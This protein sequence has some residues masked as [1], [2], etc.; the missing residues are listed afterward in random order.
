[1][2]AIFKINSENFTEDLI[3]KIKQL[4]SK[5]SYFEIR[6]IETEDETDYLLSSVQNKET[7]LKSIKEMEEGKM[8]KI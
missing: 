1:M 5:N 3:I 8:V 4:F 7:L 6:V 2:E